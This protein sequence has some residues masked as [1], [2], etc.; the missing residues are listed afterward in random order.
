MLSVLLR[1][2]SPSTR[3]SASPAPW[4][5]AWLVVALFAWPSVA[6]AEAPSFLTFESG[7]VRPL[8]LSG[9]GRRLYAVNTPDGR[10]E[11]FRV[12][13]EGLAHE[14]SVP[15][16]LEPVAVAI[17]NRHEVWVVNHLSDSVSI[18]HVPTRRVTKTLLVGDEPRDIVFARGR[19]FVTTAHRGQHRTHPSI[20][21]VPGS[22]DPRLTTPGI[23]RADVWVFDARRPGHDLGGKPL[24]ILSFFADTPR[25]LAV[26]PDRSTVYAAAFHSGNQTTAV[27]ESLVCNGF[28]AAGSCTIDGTPIPGGNPGPGVN[29]EGVRAPEVGVI[30]RVNPETGHFEDE[31]GRNWDEVVRFDLPDEDVFAI[32]AT[33]LERR[34]SWPHVGTILFNMVTNPKTGALYVSNTEARNEVRFEGPGEF[35]DSTVQGHLHEARITVIRGDDVAPRHL[36]KH[37]DYSVR[38]APPGV[39]EHSLATPVEMAVSKNGRKLYVAAFGSSRIGVFDT[40]ALEDD[41]FDPTVASADYLDVSGGGPAGLVLDERRGR[42]YVLT[43]FDNAVSVLDLDSGAETAH[44]PLYNPEPEHVVTGRPVLYD[45]Q[46]TSSNGEASCAGC[47]VFGDLDSIG[48]DLGNPD[49]DLVASPLPVNLTD[50]INIA[51]FFDP[52]FF[53]FLNGTGRANDF[54]AMKGP[55][56][57]QTL[58]GMVNSG[59]MH[60]RG[61]RAAGFFG[62]D[63]P[64]GN[65]ADL[66]F[67]NFIVAVPG[68]LGADR[69]PS[70]PDLQDEMQR[71]ADFTLDVVLPPNPVR[72]LDQTLTAEQARGKEFYFGGP[73]GTLLSDGVDLNPGFTGFTCN[74]CHVL[75]PSQG[76]FGTNGRQSFELEEQTMKIPHLRNLYTKVGMFGMASAPAFFLPGDN[77]DKGAQVRGFGFLHDGSTDTLFRFFR[78]LVFEKSTFAAPDFGVDGGGFTEGDPQRAAMEEFMLAFDSDLAPIVGQQV[79]LSRKNFEEGG[80]RVDLMLERAETPF[81]SKILGGEVT[82]CDLVVRTHLFGQPRGWLYEGDDT[83]LSDD[84]TTPSEEDLR[85]LA[86]L[87]PLTYTCAPPGSGRRMAIDRDEDD[88]LDGLDLCPADP[89]AAQ[90]DADGDRLGDACDNCPDT[91]NPWQLDSDGNG[92]GEA[93]E[94]RPD[95]PWW[96]F[97]FG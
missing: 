39:K 81:V 95:R 46:T 90:V 76:F 55:M 6:A 36:N 67:R 31:L 64:E 28:E 5:A 79:T 82:E 23:G 74:G 96:W 77:G 9:D 57:T 12:G 92:V 13:S 40:A 73:D 25:A 48:W 72:H 26:S 47:H 78:S 11:I 68:L 20:A 88:L 22:G 58:R 51:R 19:A 38:P 61:D 29:H 94:S 63:T 71:F 50:V 1:L 75:D 32:D 87:V 4:V 62:V 8:A 34:G 44:L 7:A 18:V 30:V 21:D 93:C 3:L 54:N 49:D 27:S 70:D 41:S 69:S 2:G 16:G 17:R 52:G 45:A 80:E 35:A 43:R 66:S 59:H 91:W 15:V 42:L 56:T 85:S 60:W 37:I 10:L 53:P 14:A 65:D 24:R 89:D 86:A 33:T 84:G 83:F 97:L